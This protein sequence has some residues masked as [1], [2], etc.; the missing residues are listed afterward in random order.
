VKIRQET[1]DYAYAGLNSGQSSPSTHT[2]YSNSSASLPPFSPPNHRGRSS[3]Y[4][5]SEQAFDLIAA[6]SHA[7]LIGLPL[8]LFI[9]IN[10]E[11]GDLE[12]GRR[13]QEALSAWLKRAGQWL[14]LRGVKLTYIW[15]LEHASGAGLHTH[16]LLHCPHKHHAAFKK[17]GRTSWAV[18]AGMRP[19][20]GSR[21]NA[22]YYEKVGPRGYDGP[23]A[24]PNHHQTYYNQ[25]KGILKY[26]LKAI[27]PEEVVKLD[28]AQRLLGDFLKVE[29]NYSLP[30]Y[31]RRLS[32]SEN[33]SKKA[34][35]AYHAEREATIH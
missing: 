28:Q 27:N 7:R 10:F 29:E 23:N 19:A 31:G 6:A 9:T 32:R 33:I 1:A 5:G 12:S 18:K 3:E 8:N 15:V 11:A 2:L 35:E 24:L 20:T 34:R 26:H 21:Q 30:I 14:A 16:I 17:M 13:G 22:I 25:L 4:I